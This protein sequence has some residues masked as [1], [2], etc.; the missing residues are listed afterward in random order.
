MNPSVQE[1]CR[2]RVFT[3]RAGY[4]E[5]VNEKVTLKDLFKIW[6]R[7]R[8]GT[9][10]TKK[11]SFE[12]FKT[13]IDQILEAERTAEDGVYQHLRLCYD[14]EEVEEFLAQVEAKKLQW[15]TTL[16]SGEMADQILANPNRR[17]LVRGLVEDKRRLYGDCDELEAKIDTL[18]TETLRL[19]SALREVSAL[20]LQIPNLVSVLLDPIKRPQSSNHLLQSLPPLHLEVSTSP[21]APPR[22]ASDHSAPVAQSDSQGK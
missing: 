7:Y 22:G 11:V 12:E 4:E 3:L 8:V 2:E 9:K 21:V 16:P 20:L 18:E 10:G 5:V 1:F 17:E 19:K 13:S 6:N 14:M 15:D